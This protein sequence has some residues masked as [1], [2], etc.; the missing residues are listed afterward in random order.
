MK[1]IPIEM[2]QKK[3]MTKMIILIFIQLILSF[4]Y[5]QSAKEIFVDSF[6]HIYEQG[7]CGDNIQRLVQIYQ[8]SG[9]DLSDSKIIEITNQGLSVFGLVNVEF[10]RGAG[11][12]A[13]NETLGKEVRSPGEKNWYHHVVLLHDGKIYD[14]D[15][16][17][18]PS[19]LSPGDY[20]T[21][22]FF[23]ELLSGYG[24]FYVGEREKRKNYQLL[25][26]QALEVLE[27][28]Q[29]RTPLPKSEVMTL[30]DFLKAF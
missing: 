20:F 9:I 1:E 8:K 12:L 2:R 6:D 25:L 15:F 22:M 28:V 13:F 7:R 5:G 29:S 27:S 19:V 30:D 16:G 24:T 11:H 17:N 21:K 3:A 10:A 18:Y 4:S 14:F 26:R 23:Q